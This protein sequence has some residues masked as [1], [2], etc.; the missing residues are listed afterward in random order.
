MITKDPSPHPVAPPNVDLRQV[1]LVGYSQ[2]G[3]TSLAAALAARVPG[4]TVERCGQLGLVKLPVD[5]R[6]IT[7]VDVSGDPDFVGLRRSAVQAVEAV[8]F[9]I[10]AIHGIDG[11][12]AL[13]WQECISQGL[14]CAVVI[15]HLDRPGADFEQASADIAA[16][17]AQDLAMV[18]LPIHDEPDPRVISIGPAGD[19]VVGVLDLLTGVIHDQRSPETWHQADADTLAAISEPQA[20]LQEQ[21]LGACP[22]PEIAELLLTEGATADQWRTALHQAVAAGALHPA[23]PVSPKTGVGLPQLLSLLAQGFPPPAAAKNLRSP[24][25]EPVDLPDQAIAQIIST[26]PDHAAIRLY[27]GGLD[28]GRHPAVTQV[29]GDSTGRV[30]VELSAD[31]S[32]GEIAVIAL[33]GGQV[34]ATLCWGEL[35]RLPEPIAPTPTRGF[36]LLGESAVG[37]ATWLAKT[38]QLDPSAHYEANSGILWVQGPRH[39]EIILAA[40][41]AQCGQEISAVPIRS[42][43]WQTLTKPVV[44]HASGDPSYL[45]EIAPA[46]AGTGVQL[47]PNLGSLISHALRQFAATGWPG[48]FPLTDVLI[49]GRASAASEIE[50]GATPPIDS[51]ALLEQFDLVEVSFDSEYQDA[52]VPDL[53]TRR[54]EILQLTEPV[55]GRMAVTA[56]VPTLALA[57]L[58]VDLRALAQGTGRL[59]R[60]ASRLR[61][62]SDDLARRI[63]AD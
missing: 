34:G 31:L 3:K 36:R 1:L 50:Y 22:D 45:L 43:Y 44:L 13:L 14:S 27:G 46:A 25:G 30:E 26:A 42:G 56:E 23:L 49:S 47:A 52:V 7:L 54:G 29:R 8:V 4:S 32:T 28:A 58:E 55:P 6:S 11:R 41:T 21:I 19:R 38:G 39:L 35:A 17:L 37:L 61:R 53:Q 51:T 40:L 60:S 57:G 18:A 12:T 5:G 33:P 10:S 20:R 24:E 63:L 62:V 59:Q 48:G 9:V 16:R 15:T 2:V